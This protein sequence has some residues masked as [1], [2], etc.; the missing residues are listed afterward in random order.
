MLSKK[1]IING[2]LSCSA[3]GLFT[4]MVVDLIQPNDAAREHADAILNRADEII[5]LL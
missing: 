4:V 3:A 1:P 5:P 2:I